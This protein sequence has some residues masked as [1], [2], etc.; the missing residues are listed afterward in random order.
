MI[1]S[2]AIILKFRCKITTRGSHKMRDAAKLVKKNDI[3]KKKRI[4]NVH[5]GAGAD[6]AR[7][8]R[9]R[10]AGCRSNTNRQTSTK[11]KKKGHKICISQKKAVNLHAN[12]K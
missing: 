9:K 5:K 2:Y 11:K 12:L 10:R 6:A 3:G 1:F 8:R 4:K 7:R